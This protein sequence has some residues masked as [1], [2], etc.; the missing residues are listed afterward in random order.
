MFIGNLPCSV[1]STLVYKGLFIG[2]SRLAHRIRVREP[3]AGLPEVLTRIAKGFGFES[4]SR[5]RYHNGNHLAIFGLAPARPLH[6]LGCLYF[7]LLRSVELKVPSLSAFSPLIYLSANDIAMD[8]AIG[9]SFLYAHDN[10]GF[11]D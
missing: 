8:S 7:G 10:Q 6:I 2:S 3:V 9:P 1:Y 4:A 11:R 5:Y